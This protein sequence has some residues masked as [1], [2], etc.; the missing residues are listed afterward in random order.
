MLSLVYIENSLPYVAERQN[1]S[2]HG[3]LLTF[4]NRQ[5]YTNRP[6][7]WRRKTYARET[8]DAFCV[9]YFSSIPNPDDLR[10]SDSDR[11]FPLE[12]SSIIW[13]GR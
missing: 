9:Y 2:I 5:R 3:G 10:S 8:S 4:Q 6:F 13:M 7:R 1:P 11:L 12:R